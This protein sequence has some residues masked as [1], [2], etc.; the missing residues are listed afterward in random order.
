MSDKI[1]Y[2]LRDS[3]SMAF[4]RSKSNT[5]K[6]YI[7]APDIKNW[8]MIREIYSLPVAR[9]A[10]NGYVKAKWNRIDILPPGVTSITLDIIPTEPAIA[11]SDQVKIGNLNKEFFKSSATYIGDILS[12]KV[13]SDMEKKIISQLP[14]NK[15]DEIFKEYKK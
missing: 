3:K 11:T 4:V 6:I 9:D 15:I 7:W 5:T 2:L 10:W 1:Y 13:L 14:S 12:D 8:D